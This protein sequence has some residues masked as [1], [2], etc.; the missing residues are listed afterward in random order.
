MPPSASARGA[1][2]RQRLLRATAAVIA[3]DGWG[4]VTTRRVAEEAG[5]TSGLVHYHFA[6]VDDLRRQATVAALDRLLIPVLEHLEANGDFTGTLADLLRELNGVNRPDVPEVAL[7]YEAFLA[8]FRDDA[9]R[10]EL[11]R[12]LTMFR[13]RTAQLLQRANAE[14]PDDLAV[15]VAAAVD[16]ILLHALIDPDLDPSRIVAPLSRLLPTGGHL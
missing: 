9:I 1:D 12:A 15:L 5:L 13:E 4:A 3:R 8:A 16:G 10:A 2:T 6:S 7:V 14:E 11:A